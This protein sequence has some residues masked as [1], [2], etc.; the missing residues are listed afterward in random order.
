[1]PGAGSGCA[2][3]SAPAQHHSWARD[4]AAPEPRHHSNGAGASRGRGGH[5]ASGAWPESAHTRTAMADRRPSLRRVPDLMLLVGVAGWMIGL[6]AVAAGLSAPERDPK[7]IFPATRGAHDFD[8]AP[9]TSPSGQLACECDQPSPP[10]PAPDETLASV[11]PRGSHLGPP[12]AKPYQVPGRIRFGALEPNEPPLLEHDLRRYL[13]QTAQSARERR[14][15]SL[16]TIWINRWSTVSHEFT[17]PQK[18]QNRR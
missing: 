7:P 18:V 4:E 3:A 5:H 9:F 11:F 1:V 13:L 16:A 8:P 10:A 14:P 2:Q 15:S 6:S 17:V 12:P